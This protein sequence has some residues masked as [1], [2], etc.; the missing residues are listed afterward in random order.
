MGQ[1]QRFHGCAGTDAGIR[2]ATLWPHDESDVIL[3]TR[4]E[5]HVFSEY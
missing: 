2:L 5:A 3:W 4:L 1:P